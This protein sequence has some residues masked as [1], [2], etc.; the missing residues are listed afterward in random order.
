MARHKN[1]RTA[2]LVWDGGAYTPDAPRSALFDDI[3]FS[4]DGLEEADHVFV[5]GNDLR[6]RFQNAQRFSIGELGFGTGLN[7]LSAWNAWQK[8]AKPSGA[9]LCFFSVEAF[10]LSQGDMARTHSAWPALRG[11]SA[12]LRAALPPPSPG[13][14]CMNFGDDV[15]LTLFYG[16][17]K[18]GLSIAEGAID[19]WFLDGFAP[20]KNPDMWSPPLFAELARLSADGAS[21]ATFTVAGAVRKALSDVGFSVTKAPGFGRKR[22]MLKGRLEQATPQRRVRLP[23]FDTRDRGRLKSGAKIA[24]IGAGIAGAS[25]AHAL[26]RAGFQPAIY[27]TERPASGASG[28][29][30]GLIM[31]RLDVDDTPE[32]RFHLSAYLYTVALIKSVQQQSRATLYFPCGALRH[33]TDEREQQ[34]QEKLLAAMPMPAAWMQS[35]KDGIFFPQGG[36]IDP[37]AFVNALIADTP[38]RITKVEKLTKANDRWTIEANDGTQDAFDAVVIANGLNA[39]KFQQTRGLP[40]AGSAGQVDWFPAAAAPDHAHVF[41]AYAAPAPSIG[42]KKSGLVIGATYSPMT[43]A[44]APETLLEATQSNINVVRD[45]LPEFA[46]E[47]T[48]EGSTPRSSIRCVT[49]DFLP[50][51]GPV[52]DWGFYSGA[53]DGLRHGR[54]QDYPPGEIL[55]GLFIL[56]GLGSRGLVTGPL[57]AAMIASEI[58]SAPAP[59]DANVAEALH[60]A[61]FF[62]RDLK[63]PVTG[64]NGV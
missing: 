24:I 14:H 19:A 54:R 28:N 5:D 34:R 56:T 12:E 52:P 40:L 38:L 1:I 4:G 47:L 35:Q 26:R 37:A 48:P 6:S 16:R 20:S 57:A 36:V 41:G 21:L 45:R 62:I 55:G 15:C 31:P 43:G 59:V 27:E 11:L 18:D 58:S 39:L 44:D 42:D 2:E 7:F 25:L 17:A 61:R 33:I 51:V 53:Y 49:P 13:F 64:E 50:I 29:P 8:A 22:D 46:G 10:P 63:R 9:K 32:G 23:W 60:P 30:A 3:Y